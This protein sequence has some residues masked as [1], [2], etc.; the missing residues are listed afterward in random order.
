MP[1]EGHLALFLPLETTLFREGF[2]GREGASKCPAKSLRVAILLW[3]AF[4]G[5]CRVWM[6][7]ISILS[8]GW[9]SLVSERHK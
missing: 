9:E 7:D 2:L 8:R 4:L 5:N 3:M 1:L 6:K